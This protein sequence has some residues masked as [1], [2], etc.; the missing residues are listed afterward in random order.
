[1][2]DAFGIA[3]LFGDRNVGSVSSSD[4]HSANFSLFVICFSRTIVLF[5][6]F[7]RMCQCVY[8]LNLCVRY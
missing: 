8:E 2:H 7:A 1:M 3:Q 5:C 4:F 6:D